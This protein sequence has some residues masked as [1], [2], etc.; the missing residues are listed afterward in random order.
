MAVPIVHHSFSANVRTMC[1]SHIT[2]LAMVAFSGNWEDVSC[3]RCRA[4]GREGAA[5]R[6]RELV[7]E[8]EGLNRTDRELALRSGERAAVEGKEVDD[9]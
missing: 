2:G 3:M 1:G 5:T 8:L 6:R 4:S 9:G 7:H